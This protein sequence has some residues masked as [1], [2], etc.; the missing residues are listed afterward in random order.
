MHEICRIATDTKDFKLL[1]SET[2]QFLHC[3]SVYLEECRVDETRVVVDEL[4][5]EHLEGV[6]VLVVCLRP[7]VLPVCDGACNDLKDPSADL[8][9]AGVGE[10]GEAGGD[11]TRKL[12]E[13]KEAHG[14]LVHED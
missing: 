8:N 4:K 13:E 6:A 9:H 11:E 14:A 12:S 7:R 10:G 5:E 2:G 3:R 1:L